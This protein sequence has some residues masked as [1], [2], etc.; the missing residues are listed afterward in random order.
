MGRV[1]IYVEDRDALRAWRKRSTRRWVWPTAR[2]G[3][4]YPRRCTGGEVADGVLGSWQ[5]GPSTFAWVEKNGG[6][7]TLRRLWAL[8]PAVIGRRQAH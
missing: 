7:R 5:R 3:R 4:S 1:L 6:P 2:S 8:S